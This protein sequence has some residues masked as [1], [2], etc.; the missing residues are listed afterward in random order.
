MTIAQATLEIFWTAFRSL[1]KKNKEVVVARLLKDKE[2]KDDLMDVALIEQRR[3]ESSRPLE[4]YLT[5]RKKRK[6]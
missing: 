3:K 1:S 4:E 5:D 6:F 2:F